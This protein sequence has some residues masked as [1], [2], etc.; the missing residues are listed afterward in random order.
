MNK[1]ILLPT[2]FSKNSWN[3]IQYAINLYENELCDFYVL[4]TY[5]K[6]VYGLDSYEILDPDHLFNKSSEKRSKEGLGD[7]MVRLTFQNDNPKHRF[8]VLSYSTM[9][10]STIKKVVEDLQFDLIV[11]GA[12][13]TNLNRA[14]QYGKNTLDVIENVRHCP[15]LVV[16]TNVTFNHPKEIVL[17]TNFDRDFNIAEVKHLADI[18]Q[19]TKASIEVVSTIDNCDLTPQQKENKMLLR[20]NFKNIDYRFRVLHNVKMKSALSCFVEIRHS[21]MISFI[22]KKPSLF[23]WLGLGSSSLGKLGFFKDVPVLALHG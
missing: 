7:I 12:K 17:V 15:I 2:D 10:L 23:E 13:G 5:A 14:K 3:A 11:M 4:N 6:E 20:Q 16:P 22:D 19:I 21:G 18:A 8:F 1:K 9:F